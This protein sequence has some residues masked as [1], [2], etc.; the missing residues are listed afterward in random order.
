[1]AEHSERDWRGWL[2]AALFT[3][4][5]LFGGAYIDVVSGVMASVPGLVERVTTL[6]ESKRNTESALQ[7]IKSD[8]K[9]TKTDIKEIKEL[10]MRG[11]K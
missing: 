4:L 8:V 2:I 5:L 9:E 1:M 7:D 10:I 3:L 11:Q 6:E